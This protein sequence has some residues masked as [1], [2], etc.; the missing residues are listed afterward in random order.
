M[1][2]EILSKAR[3]L[4]QVKN[5]PEGSCDISKLA[6]ALEMA[7]WMKQQMIEKA[8]KW[9][10]HNIENFLITDKYG[11]KFFDTEPAFED[12]KINIM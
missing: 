4:T 12:F 1:N 3:Q 10:W 6:V 5:E 7:D 8:E 2:N 11:D 9:F